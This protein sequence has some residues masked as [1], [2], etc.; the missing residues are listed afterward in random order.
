MYDVVPGNYNG[1]RLCMMLYQVTM[2][3]NGSCMRSYT[4]TMR[5]IGSELF[6]WEIEN[7]ITKNPT[8]WWAISLFLI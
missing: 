8:G 3:L 6:G 7:F 1:D 5:S 4:T 2:K